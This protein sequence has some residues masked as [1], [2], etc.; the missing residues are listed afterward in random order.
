MD[1]KKILPAV[2]I[3]AGIFTAATGIV[4]GGHIISGTLGKGFAL[5]P[6][7]TNNVKCTGRLT[8]SSYLVNTGEPVVLNLKSG[9][10]PGNFVGRSS[11]HN[12]TAKYTYDGIHQ[13]LIYADGRDYI[14]DEA[15]CRFSK[16][17][18]YT[19]KG[20]ITFRWKTDSGKVAAGFA[21]YYYKTI[22]MD[23]IIRVTDLEDAAEPVQPGNSGSEE[24][25]IEPALFGEVSH[26][27]EWEENRQDFND[28]CRETGTTQWIRPE[29]TYFSG[30]KF[31]LRADAEGESPPSQITVSIEGTEYKTRL[32][33][34]NGHWEGSLF[35]PSMIGK[36]GL[37][38]REKLTFSFY[39]V[40]D[41]VICEYIED[42]F[43]DD[44]QPYWLMH[45]KE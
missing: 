44:S 33:F 17:G 36:W 22:W 24:E 29:N 15:V 12:R 26:T 32:H 38:G 18:D 3:M 41:G 21:R 7:S 45:R 1:R 20:Y 37:N 34:R 43:V 13:L 5:I 11:S 25:V 19:V 23:C 6:G 8:A 16:P 9:G 39:A 28:R 27:E 14:S 10:N 2:L 4:F 40:I 42:V 35:D 30:E 31:M